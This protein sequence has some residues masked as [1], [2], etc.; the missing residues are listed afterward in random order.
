LAEGVIELE[1]N[2]PE[3]D[4]IRLE[5]KEVMVPGAAGIFTVLPNHTP[6]LST[7]TT[8]V[9]V[10]YGQGGKP[11]FFAVSG[12]FAE[13]IDDRIV[14]LTDTVE[15]ADTIDSERASSARERAEERLRKPPED[16]DV[17]RAEAALQRALVRLQAHGREEY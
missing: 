6:L 17:M 8:G 5:A 15:M 7:L 3:R 1:L 10:A 13:V 14:I 16:L 2:A 11:E 9:V 4:P 12:G